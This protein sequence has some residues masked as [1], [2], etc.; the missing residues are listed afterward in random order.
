MAFS[1]ARCRFAAHREA[2]TVRIRRAGEIRGRVVP[3]RVE[4]TWR[5]V[6]Y[7]SVPAGLI[8]L[9]A[10]C[11]TPPSGI[12]DQDALAA[13]VGGVLERRGLGPDA[14]RVID[15][16]MRHETP[17]PPGATPVVRELLARPL[18][19]VDAAALFD[20]AIPP[21]LR[22]LADA[23]KAQV[24]AV[25]MQSGIPLQQFPA[26]W[27]YLEELAAA[28]RELRQALPGGV[29]DGKAAVLEL[30]RQPPSPDRLRTVGESLDAAGI[31]RAAGKFLDA[32][33][34]FVLA[35]RAAGPALRF[36]DEV[37][38][39]DSAVG[40]VVIGTHGDDAHGPGAAL[41][42]DPG[43]NDLYERAPATGGTVS[44]II[45]LGG[46]DLYAGSDV[47]VHGLSA[48]VDL[49]GDDRY[50]MTGPGLGAAIAGVS[51]LVDASGDDV[52][53][54]EYFGQGAAAFGLGALID[55]AGNDTY[56]VRAGG[57]GF[58]MAGGV[59]LL[60]DAAGDDIYAASGIEDAFKR[61]GGISSAQGAAFGF[62]TMLGAGI[63]ILRDDAGNDRYEAEM[64]A[65]GV[66]FY[67]GVGLLWDRGGNDRY[68]AVRYAQGNGVHEAVGILRDESGDDRY[69][70]AYGVGQGMGLDLAVGVLFDGAGNDV[71]RS[72]VLAQGTATANG[73]GLL[74]DGGGADRWE[75]GA[76]RRSWGRAEWLRGLPSTGL[77][78]YEPLSAVFVREGKLEEPVPAAAELGGPLGGAPVAH[79]AAGAGNCPKATDA[80][81]AAL[82]FTEAL[83]RITPGLGGGARDDAAYAEVQRHL[84]T[85]LEAAIA[86]LPRDSFNIVWALGA[87]LHC[88]LIDAV[89]DEA[90]EMWAGMGRLLESDPATP[91]AG[92]I[93]GA[94]RGRPPPAL[95]LRA[96]LKVLD[97][98]PSCGVRAAA[99]SLRLAAASDD[100][101]R[102][103]AVQSAQA[104][105]NSSCWRLQAT[106]RNLLRRQGVAPP[107][108][109]ATP[110]FLRARTPAP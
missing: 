42:I 72:G 43:G 96:A 4:M 29:L 108:N 107:D 87:A 40:M 103:A 33:A 2:G 65:Q 22:R 58:G 8:L 105:L 11:V 21:A 68:R 12:A 9:L 54:A 52:Y 77:L 51:V 5:N 98:H 50:A 3:P 55:L 80:A 90:I 47:A 59:G 74:I 64:F 92:A 34:R 17:P 46:S 20:R 110:S 99:L 69:E 41:I 106:A 39:F 23:V 53:S 1:S 82:P 89:E 91:F 14:L 10:A 94:L 66:G 101:A 48:L 49:A 86:E 44:V 78:L 6:L 109:P 13:R 56:R 79:E 45:D 57:Q 36:P 104:A 71:Y 100:T 25:R 83:R 93:A 95:Q 97:A 16:I 24:P 76:D 61:G 32:T 15:N 7:G 70:L 19:A 84:K 31:E 88:A 62:R 60:W 38:R 27:T 67:Y 75:M 26:L 35:L 73:F 81:T 30:A 63:G 28:Q 37:V 18:A 85:R 102:A